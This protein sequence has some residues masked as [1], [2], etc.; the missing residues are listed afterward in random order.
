[1]AEKVGVNG[2]VRA[3]LNE[4]RSKD[5]ILV[6]CRMGKMVGCSDNSMVVFGS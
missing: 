6:G 1:M 5:D 2:R 3:T 4:V